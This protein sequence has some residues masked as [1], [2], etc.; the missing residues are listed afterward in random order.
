MQPRDHARMAGARTWWITDTAR[1]TVGWLQLCSLT[2]TGSGS[3]CTTRRAG[4]RSERG[5]WHEIRGVPSACGP[6]STQKPRTWITSLH[7]AGMWLRSI[8]DHSNRYVI[9][10][11]REKP[12]GKLIQR[13]R[14]GDMKKFSTIKV[15]PRALFFASFFPNVRNLGIDA[16]A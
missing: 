15:K 4:G 1:I 16:G 13:L 9:S 11:T 5:S 3:G 7:T 12:H 2:S 14:G 8:A 10:V 6:G